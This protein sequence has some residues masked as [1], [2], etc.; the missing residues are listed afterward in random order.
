[1]KIVDHVLLLHYGPTN[2]FKFSEC[3]LIDESLVSDIDR[4][5]L[6]L[7]RKSIKEFVLDVWIEG[8]YKIPPCLFSCQSLLHLKLHCCWLKPPTSIEGFRN[9]KSLY[10]NLVRMAQ[11]AFENLISG[12]PLLETLKLIEVEGFSQINIDSPSLKF[13]KIF[14]DFEGISFV[15]SF[16]LATVVVDLGLYLN[17]EGNQG[18]LHGSSSNLLKFFDHRPYIQSLVI[19]TCFLKV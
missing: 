14:G 8:L 18:R 11:D 1:L 19:E 10:L 3:A 7:S 9:L 5:I 15:N 4:W 6:Y 16:Q 12:C 2:V 17:S 13:L